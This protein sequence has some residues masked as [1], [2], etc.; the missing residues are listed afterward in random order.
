L[1][2]RCAN[3]RGADQT[4]ERNMIDHERESSTEFSD[5]YVLL[6]RAALDETNSS[7][8]P[9]MREH[10]LAAH[11]ARGISMSGK[12]PASFS[13][14]GIVRSHGSGHGETPLL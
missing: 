11:V 12:T 6:L 8:T 4:P 14:S 13:Q 10:C 9:P 5:L 1:L 3:V 7:L 2:K